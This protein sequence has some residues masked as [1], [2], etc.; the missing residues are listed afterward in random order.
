MDKSHRQTNHRLTPQYSL[1]QKTTLIAVIASFFLLTSGVAQESPLD[2]LYLEIDRSVAQSQTYTAAKEKQIASTKHRMRQSLRPEEELFVY[3]TLF[4]EYRS[5]QN[6]SA[7]HYLNLCLSKAGAQGNEDLYAEYTALKANQAALCGMY[8]DALILFDRI[9]IEGRGIRA[10]LAY[11]EAGEYIYSELRTYTHLDS[12]AARFLELKQNFAQEVAIRIDPSSDRGLQGKEVE[13]YNAG[14]YEGALHYS[15]KRLSRYG[16]KDRQYAIIAYF[17][18]LDYELAGDREMQKYWLAKSA[19]CDIQNAV[20]DQGSLWELASILNQEGQVERAHTYLRYAW[21]CAT[22]FNTRMRTAQISPLLSMSERAFQGK[23]QGQNKSL[24][25]TLMAISVLLLVLAGMLIYIAKQRRRLMDAQQ[26]LRESNEKLSE[27]NDEVLRSNN[28]LAKLN[29]ELKQTNRIMEGYVGHFM[30]MCSQYINDGSQYRRYV[31]K[32]LRMN[33]Q[34]QLRRETDNDDDHD[35]EIQ[36]FYEHFDSAFLS[37]FPNFVEDFNRLLRPEERIPYDPEK[38]L[39]T[40][41]RLFA[42]IRLGITDSSKIAEFLHYSVN[43][44]YTYRTRVKNAALDRST[45]EDQV[46]R[47]GLP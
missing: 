7:M 20:M 26:R 15:D 6:D 33:K 42:L 29:E 39:P 41:I 1:M 32:M 22:F 2:S 21:D 37:L 23:L 14:D 10:Q 16:E 25:Y 5:Y 24:I 13:R 3:R 38:G 8:V 30:S 45:F 11:Y 44:I 12:L 47:I 46:M 43:T 31:N 36:E 17:R 9:D 34:E 40:Q 35:R 19:L 4:E 28:R 18:S 27:V